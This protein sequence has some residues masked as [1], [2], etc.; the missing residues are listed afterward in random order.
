MCQHLFFC[1]C[2]WAIQYAAATSNV[3]LNTEQCQAPV[4]NNRQLHCTVVKS[5]LLVL[6][7][8]KEHSRLTCLLN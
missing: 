5:F 6:L 7:L 2:T 4:V 1:L 8:G 3:T